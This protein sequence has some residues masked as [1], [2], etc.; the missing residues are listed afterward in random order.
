M[1]AGTTFGSPAGG[2][3]SG[4][5]PGG[6]PGGV[7]LD[8]LH[9]ELIDRLRQTTSLSRAEAERVLGDVLD[10]FGESTRALVRRRHREL[11]AAGR[12]NPVVFDRIRSEL[13]HHR[14]TTPPLSARQLRRI[15]YG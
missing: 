2:G 14:V 13:P 5:P 7:S 15:V 1:A 12:T 6:G 8:E 3:A 9:G 11:L 10:Y 4:T